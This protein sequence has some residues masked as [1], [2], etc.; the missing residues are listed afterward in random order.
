M[1]SL[2][3]SSGWNVGYGNCILIDH[4]NGLKTRYAHLSKI[5]VRVGQRVGTGDK[6]GAVGSSGNSTGPHLHFEVIK[7]GRTQNPLNYL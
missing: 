4:G 5:Y 7:N 2:S 1:P 6:I 3:T